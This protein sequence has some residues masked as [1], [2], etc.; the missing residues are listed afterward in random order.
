MINFE[1]AIL[2]VLSNTKEIGKERVCLE[3]ALG[4]ILAEDIEVKEDIPTFNNSAMDGYAVIEEDIKGA[5]E[6]K[7]AELKLTGTESA[8]G[9]GGI[10]VNRG[11]AVKIFTGGM[12]PEGADT[13]VPVE[14]VKE[15]DG[16][17]YVYKSFK[18]G[19]N[20]RYKGEEVK[21]GERILK[22]GI[23][24]T[25]Y[26]IGLL[27]QLNRTYV[28]V[29]AKPKVSVLS[30]GDELLELGEEEQNG[31]KIR[32]S[33]NYMLLSL[34]KKAGG[35][36]VNLGIIED[37]PEKI[38]IAFAGFERYDI[39]ITT[40]GVSKGEK[41]FIKEIVKELGINIKFHGV[42]IKPA[43]PV[44]FGIYGNRKLFFGL[45]G[46]PVSSAIA[47]DLFVYPAIKKMMGALNIF[48]ERLKAR[49]LKGFSRKNSDRKEFLRVKLWFEG[50]EAVCYPLEKQGSHMLT[51]MTEANAYAILDIGVTEVKEGETLEVIRFK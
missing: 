41:D 18:K 38:K 6:D 5:S 42:L 13:V 16:K 4:R 11:E 22:R 47:F 46:N 28:W 27:A 44:M 26:E 51:S 30:T 8:G 7:P 9:K 17:I 36:P 3:N 39:F 49:L 37:N 15:I 45:P 35:D 19:S 2:N 24:I 31:N 48:P 32:S 50:N 21:K 43:K 40:G 34:I 14:Y 33:N 10:K 1:E 25:P 29:G 20:V 23:E 12:L